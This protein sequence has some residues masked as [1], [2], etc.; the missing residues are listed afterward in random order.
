MLQVVEIYVYN[1]DTDVVRVVSLMPT[2]SWGGG[3]L[4]AEVGTGY[5]H[6]LPHSCRGTIGQSVERKVTTKESHQNDKSEK[7]PVMESHLEMEIEQGSIEPH[8]KNRQPHELGKRVEKN[9]VEN[10]EPPSRQAPADDTQSK[11]PAG[12][13]PPPKVEVAGKTPP[14]T[15][16]KTDEPTAESIQEG[17]PRAKFV[18]L[19]TPP[20]MQY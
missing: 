3:M 15:P 1:S 12:M 9:K 17:E 20:K 8:N 10:G 16:A 11:L 18:G 19:P 2:N 4:G 13:P 5:L 7:V 14:S 6:R